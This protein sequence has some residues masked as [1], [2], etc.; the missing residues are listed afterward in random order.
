MYLFGAEFWLLIAVWGSVLVI[1]GYVLAKGQHRVLRAARAH[2]WE[3][4]LLLGLPAVAG[5]LFTLTLW[6]GEQWGDV[7]LWLNLAALV[8]TY[9][10]VRRYGHE[11]LTML[12]GLETITRAIS[13]VVG[14]VETLMGRESPYML[15]DVR[16]EFYEAP[17]EFL[18]DVIYQFP[19]VQ[20]SLEG[21]LALVP[22]LW[23]MRM[24]A[25]ISRPHAFLLFG[26]TMAD[27]SFSIGSVL[28]YV[29][30]T[31]TLP[32]I[33]VAVLQ[34]GVQIALNVLL[35]WALIRF[36]TATPSVRTVAALIVAARLAWVTVYVCTLAIAV[37]PVFLGLEYGHVT[38]HP[39]HLVQLA[40]QYVMLILPYLL[41][42]YWVTRPPR[43]S[44][45]S[46]S[47]DELRNL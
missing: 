16:M 3:T 1:A 37:W 19:L 39:P 6:A 7:L 32:V 4:A 18:A 14:S 41:L 44:Q 21:A 25:R 20:F 9:P 10:F 36:E 45:K 2:P 42:G 46:P 26:L 27:G 23:F 28:P 40:W 33:G 5:F 29:L 22:V 31:P 11:F 38:L 12:W 15:I 24:A 17:F 35:L 30:S 47:A 13:R 43:T 8:A 34:L